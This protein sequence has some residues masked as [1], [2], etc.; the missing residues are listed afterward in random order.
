M[1][2][3]IHIHFSKNHFVYISS[4]S[5]ILFW[6]NRYIYHQ[7]CNRKYI[8]LLYGCV[9]QCLLRLSKR[10]LS[11]FI[12]LEQ[13]FPKWLVA[14]KA[15]P[16]LCLPKHKSMLPRHDKPKSRCRIITLS[17]SVLAFLADQLVLISLDNRPVKFN[18][19]F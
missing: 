17:F 13:I 19:Q 14:L 6:A 5:T 1:I 15:V 3:K 10:V 7:I 11:K 8:S 12:F 16:K 2:S 9:A 18:G 4:I